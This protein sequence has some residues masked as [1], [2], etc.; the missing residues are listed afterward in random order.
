MIAIFSCIITSII[1]ENVIVGITGTF[2]TLGNAGP[3]YGPIG[4]MGN[5]DSLSSVTKF[6]FSMNMIIG[7]LELIPFLA[8]LYPDFWTRSSGYEA[9]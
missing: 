7:R 1:E 3:G 8:M 6:I 4:P 2:T 5:F 9:K